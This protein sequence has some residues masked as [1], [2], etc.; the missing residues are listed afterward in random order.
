MGKWK[1]VLLGLG[2]IALTPIGAFECVYQFELP[3]IRAAL[4]PAPATNA[5]ALGLESLWLAEGERLDSDVR[6]LWTGNFF[7]TPG[8][9]PRGSS[10]PRRSR[11]GASDA[12]ASAI[13]TRGASPTAPA[14]P[15]QIA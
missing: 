1:W 2:L 9:E 15:G 8:G 14:C 3:A 11:P 12:S 4:A 13:M 6:P 10:A 5:P 7:D